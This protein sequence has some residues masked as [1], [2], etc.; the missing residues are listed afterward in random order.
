DVMRQFYAE[1]SDFN[2]IVQKLQ[3]GAAVEHYFLKDDFLLFGSRLC[4]TKELRTK[5][6]DESHAP[7]YAGHTGIQATTKAIETYFYWPSMRQDIQSRLATT[8][9]DSRSALGKHIYGFHL[10]IAKVSSGEHR[11]MDH[12]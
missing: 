12:S 3:S 1:D 9:F 6:I 4:V 5:V 8:A 2:D 7:P 10:W 11:Y